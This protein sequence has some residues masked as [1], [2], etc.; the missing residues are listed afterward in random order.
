MKYFFDASTKTAAN[1][2]HVCATTTILSSFV[3]HPAPFSLYTRDPNQTL[4]FVMQCPLI[5]GLD[6]QTTIL[7]LYVQNIIADGL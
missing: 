6:L 7:T 2:V 1:L 3:I 4:Y 5:L